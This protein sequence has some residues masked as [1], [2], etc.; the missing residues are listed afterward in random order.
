MTINLTLGPNFINTSERDHFLRNNMVQG[1]QLQQLVGATSTSEPHVY[2]AHNHPHTPQ[3]F[4]HNPSTFTTR[5]F[6]TSDFVRSSAYEGHPHMHTNDFP[7]FYDNTQNTN[8]HLHDKPQR[9]VNPTTNSNI[10]NSN[11]ATQNASYQNTSNQTTSNTNTPNPNTS[12]PNGTSFSGNHSRNPHATGSPIYQ[13][14]FESHPNMGMLDGH[15]QQFALAQPLK[16]HV[17]PPPPIISH[18]GPPMANM[19]LPQLDSLP[20]QGTFTKFNAIHATPTFSSNGVF[21]TP[22]LDMSPTIFSSG[23][24]FSN[25]NS[26]LTS[27]SH[28]F[29]VN[30]ATGSPTI[31]L[32]YNLHEFS[33][34][35]PNYKVLER[36]RNNSVQHL[37]LGL[38]STPSLSQDVTQHSLGS[39]D[40]FGS[41]LSL[42][43]SNQSATQARFDSFAAGK[44]QADGREEKE[45]FTEQSADSPTTIEINSA[46]MSP[47]LNMEDVLEDAIA[48]DDLLNSNPFSLLKPFED[49]TDNTLNTSFHTADTSGNG[50]FKD[51]LSEL[52]T[53]LLTDPAEQQAQAPVDK[54]RPLLKKKL[55]STLNNTKVSKKTLKKA[56]SFSGGVLQKPASTGPYAPPKKLKTS[57]ISFNECSQKFPAFTL[58]NNNNNISFVYESGQDE[59][60]GSAGDL[61]LK[62]SK[63]SVSLKERARDAAPKQVLK[64][65]KSGM[66]EFQIDMGKGK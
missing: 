51:I 45:L 57:V 20:L 46:H 40:N 53:I 12:N 2:F 24:N 25:Q 47:Y 11:K 39:G 5:N 38:N 3:N 50:E 19:A 66:T 23:N 65:M 63:S 1:Q 64:N 34:V 29:Y 61:T 26:S 16:E 13:G 31:Q 55:T 30:Q 9:I 43:Y 7:Q 21:Q 17:R 36:S 6:I 22:T 27:L 18:E 58:N 10:P 33:P 28:S 44:G 62:K 8:F 14:T 32:E 54:V 41:S 49:F 60:A 48:V 4:D 35:T 37:G 52:S 15:Q 59:S 56:S 42:H